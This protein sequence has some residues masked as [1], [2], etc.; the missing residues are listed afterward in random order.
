MRAVIT[1]KYGPPDVLQLK[2]VEQPV[3]HDN[4][5]LVKIHATTVNRTDCALQR[6]KP[7][8]SRFFT[9]LFRPKSQTPGTEFAGII[10]AVG[11]NVSDF[12][13][14]DRVFGFNEFGFGAH[15]EYMK[16]AQDKALAT[17]PDDLTFEQAA[18]STEGAHYAYNFINKVK[19]EKRETF[20]VNG[21]TGA[22]GSA[23]LQLLKN[24]GAHV[25]ALCDTKNTDL[26]KSL[27]ADEVIDYT[28]EDFT[29]RA[30]KYNF[31][32]DTVGKSS[33]FKSKSSLLPRG[34]YIS[35]ELGF[36]SQ[37]IFLALFTP[38][39]R[40]KKVIFPLPTNSRGSVLLIKKLIEEGQ[41]NSVIDRKYTLEKIVEAYRYVETGMKTGNVVITCLPA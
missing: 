20:L 28:K 36:M 26:I 15:A 1:T 19:F 13:V 24:M 16:I 10:E 33:F 29:K 34:V 27:G 8:I 18:A 11:K 32:F 35:S 3:P 30:Q 21:A 22:I 31:I 23:A 5:V 4:E 2:E 41:F 9:G 17:M 39:L 12:K 25:T 6:A 40:G 7:F 38:L 14:G 37:N